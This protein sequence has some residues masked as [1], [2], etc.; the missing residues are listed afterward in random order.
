MK[1]LQIVDKG[2]EGGGVAR[3]VQDLTDALRRQGHD[4]SVLRLRADGAADEASLPWTFGPLQG[5]HRLRA[6]RRLLAHLDP[7]L[8]QVHAGFTTLSPVLLRALRR[9]RPTVGMLHD[10]SP[11]C[12]LGTRRFHSGATDCQRRVGAGCVSC[13]CYRPRSV[14][15]WLRV[16]REVL[17]RAW[18]L[19]E[20]RAL[21]QLIVPSEYLRQLALRHGFDAQRVTLIPHFTSAPPDDATA[22][23]APPLIV[24][25]GRLT[26]EKGVFCLFEALARLTDLPWQAALIGAGPGREVLAQTAARHGFADRLRWHGV[27]AVAERNAVLRSA[28]LLVF[29][30]LI[31]EGFGLTGI[32]ALAYGKPVAGFPAGGASEWLRHGETGI[33]A[34]EGDAPALAQALRT[35][36]CDPALASR[37]GENGRRLVRAR[38]AAKPCIADLC[39]IYARAREGFGRRARA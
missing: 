31:A 34:A 9:A 35:L 28:Y 20:W 18:L 14:L 13:G 10:V 17:V 25:V 15:G 11:F 7:S 30:S 23:S 36:L 37:L 8:I 38:F 33:A 24:F 12:F 26:R 5:L 2:P 27:L 29:P 39:A 4:T 32:E 6:L 1:I 21:P 16:A 22:A 19:K 3:H